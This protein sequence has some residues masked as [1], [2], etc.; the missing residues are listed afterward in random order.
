[1]TRIAPL[2]LFAAL[3]AETTAQTNPGPPDSA[4]AP[5]RIEW[6]TWGGDPGSTHYSPLARINRD[7]VDR[8]RLAWEWDTGEAPLS[9]P[10]LPVPRNPVRPGSFEN[11]P[12][13]RDGVMYVSTSYNRVAALDPDTG[14]PEWIYDPRIIEWGPG[15][16]R[17]RIRPPGSGR[18]GGRRGNAEGL[19]E[20]PLEAHLD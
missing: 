5:S 4:A 15:A 19:P 11:T 14:E 17:D 18:V 13:V 3:A 16:E 10:R 20:Q 9:G 8:L 6:P 12:V 7:N 2:I 1:M